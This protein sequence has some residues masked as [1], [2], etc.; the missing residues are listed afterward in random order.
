MF[1]AFPLPLY[2]TAWL[3]DLVYRNSFEIQWLNF[4]QWAMVGA[5]LFGGFALVWSSIDLIRARPEAKRRRAGYFVLLLLMFVLGFINEFIHAK[6]AYATMPAGFYM[7]FILTV[8]A[9]MAAWTGYSGFKSEEVSDAR[10][11][12]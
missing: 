3:G 12:L 9:L 1:L 4:S 5:L 6:D 11:D 10:R 8:L 2:L 7:S